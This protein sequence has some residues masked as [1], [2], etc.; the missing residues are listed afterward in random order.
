[1][2][3]FAFKNDDFNVNIKEE[4]ED[5]RKVKLSFDFAGAFGIEE[6]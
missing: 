4:R 3:N 6:S 5:A 1:M 2:M